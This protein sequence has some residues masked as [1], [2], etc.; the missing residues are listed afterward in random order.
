MILARLARSWRIKMDSRLARLGL[1]QAK[2]VTLYHLALNDEPV[3][4]RDLA[5][6]VGVEGPTMVRL[7]DGLAR[8][9]L[10][11]REP[12]PHDRRGKVICLTE[13]AKPVVEDM[14]AVAERLREEIFADLSK[15]E[16]ATC[17]SA[18]RRVQRNLDAA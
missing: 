9:G 1:T 15:A 7:L 6:Q 10:I 3:L 17:V 14:L 2:W 16:L 12:A 4:Q 5:D 11:V 18:L 8:M 13:R